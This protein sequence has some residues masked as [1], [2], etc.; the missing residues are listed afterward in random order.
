MLQRVVPERY[1][2]RGNAHRIGNIGVNPEASPLAADAALIGKLRPYL[3]ACS[4]SKSD[5]R[6]SHH[7][8]HYSE[9]SR[10]QN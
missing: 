3:T 10:S 5:A 6:R 8:A 7:R 4:L 9:Q 2:E 1:I